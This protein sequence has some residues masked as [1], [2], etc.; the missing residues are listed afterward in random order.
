MTTYRIFDNGL[1]PFRIKIKKNN[2][3]KIY[4]SKDTD[5]YSILF[6]TFNP[7]KIFVGK[8][9][10]TP[11]TNYSGDYG[12]YFDGN[13]ILLHLGGL[14]YIF[15]GETIY[16]FTSKY[17][18]VKYVSEIGN[19]YVPYPYAIDKYNY[20]YLMIEDVVIYANA[21]QAITNPYIWYY[22][23]HYLTSFRPGGHPNNPRHVENKNHI[24]WIKDFKI[25]DKSYA[26]N[27]NPDPESNYDRLTRF[28]D[29]KKTNISVIK[30]DGH[31]KILTKKDY[32]ELMSQFAIKMK[33]SK[34]SNKKMIHEREF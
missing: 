32:I 7:K 1:F 19:N 9:P 8:S 3:V 14:E 22:D 10:L 11:M 31:E 5:D 15:I 28:D 21:S 6:K 26:L 24:T 29:D 16:S 33:F 12:S 23:N 2:K 34:I 20:V 30:H 18:I 4:K 27:Y 13:S 17:E 25:G